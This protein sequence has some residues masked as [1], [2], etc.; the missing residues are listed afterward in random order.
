M[1]CTEIVSEIQ[2]NFCTQH[3][4]PMF[5]KKRSF[6]QKFTCKQANW[7]REFWKVECDNFYLI[8][9]PDFTW[10][11]MKNLCLRQV[12]VIFFLLDWLSSVFCFCCWVLLLA[13]LQVPKVVIKGNH[14]RTPGSV[15]SR[16]GRTYR[17]GWDF[18]QLMFAEKLLL[19]IS[20]QFL[21]KSVHCNSCAYFLW[22]W[23][24][25]SYW[26]QPTLRSFRRA[27]IVYLHITPLSV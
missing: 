27:W 24:L 21:D 3:V 10:C 2:N 16:P 8:S 6:W 1:L 25:F 22:H 5:C 15:D 26:S 23:L 18:S 17:D 7:I 19:K 9:E 14:S 4:L 13:V 20:Y 12:F 11:Y